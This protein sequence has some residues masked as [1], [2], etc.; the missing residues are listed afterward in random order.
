MTQHGQAFWTEAYETHFERLYAYALHRLTNGNQ[1]E[2]EEL[3]GEAFLRAM[4]Y[5][6]EPEAVKNLLAY[7][8]V[9]ARRILILKR[10]RENS[11][12]MQSLESL[13]E[14]G[15]EPKVEFDVHSFLETEEYVAAYKL[16]RGPLPRREETLITLHLE[17]YTCSEIAAILQ[18]DERVTRSD[19]NRVR[20]KVHYRLS[21]VK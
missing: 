18:E 19:L 15:R 13:V 21:K 10:R 8:F 9:T 2:A 12:N 5:V 1:G 20:A 11:Q 16:K 17:G 14:A 4:K 3:A 6:K 7:L